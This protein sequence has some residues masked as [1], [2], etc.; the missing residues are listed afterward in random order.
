MASAAFRWKED[1]IFAKLNRAPE[2]TK[3]AFKRKATSIAGKMTNYAKSNRPWIDRTGKARAGLSTKTE[4]TAEHIKIEI[5]HQVYYGVY[6]EFGMERRFAILE[7]TVRIFAPQ[8]MTEFTNF[9]KDV[10]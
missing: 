10:L 1:T 3:Q 9:L 5:S 2:A 7:P 8:A 6:L 4:I